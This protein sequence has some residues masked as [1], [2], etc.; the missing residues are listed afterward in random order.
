MGHS[1]RRGRDAAGAHDTDGRGTVRV[2]RG[3]RCARSDRLPL[4]HRHPQSVSFSLL[5]VTRPPLAFPTPKNQTMSFQLHE[6]I[7]CQSQKFVS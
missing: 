7:F 2:S 6:N 4:P 3:K 1:G 5:P